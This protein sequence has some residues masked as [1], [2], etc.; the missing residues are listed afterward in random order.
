ME[1]YIALLRGINVS[2]QKK[3][4]MDELRALM[5]KAGLQKVQTYIQSG[6][7]IFQSEDK[8]ADELSSTIQQAIF[9]TYQFEVPTLIKKPEDLQKAVD[10]N[11]FIDKDQ[12][13][14]YLTLLEAQPQAEKLSLLKSISHDPEEWVIEKDVI[15]F[16]S[17]QGYGRAKMNNNYFEQ[18][19]KVKATTRNWKTIN[20]LVE[21]AATL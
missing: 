11:P 6:N 8:S 3:I 2:G 5:S 9:D 19:L 18:K 17:P 20:K 10:E 15:Y 14:L 21:M 4:K 16:F 1:S 13:R 7:I 12:S